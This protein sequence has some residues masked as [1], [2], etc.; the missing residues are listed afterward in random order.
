M[1]H[2]HNPDGSGR[3]G[4]NKIR[5]LYNPALA[6]PYLSKNDSDPSLLP[7]SFSMLHC[8]PIWLHIL[9]W[10]CLLVWL[11]PCCRMM[12]FGANYPLFLLL[13]LSGGGVTSPSLLLS[14]YPDSDGFSLI[15]EHCHALSLGDIQSESREKFVS[16]GDSQKVQ[17]VFCLL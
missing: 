12:H 15:A 1:I 2:L 16:R 4:R 5:F 10:S 6:F 13:V 9:A 3:T 17:N 11:F 14:W 7:L 8:P